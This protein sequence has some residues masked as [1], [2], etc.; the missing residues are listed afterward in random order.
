MANRHF[1]DLSPRQGPVCRCAKKLRHG[2]LPPQSRESCR[3]PS[4]ESCREKSTGRGGEVATLPPGSEVGGMA[5]GVDGQ[6]QTA[7]EAQF[8]E[9]IGEVALG[10]F[11]ADAQLVGD[12][13]VGGARDD[14][15]DDLALA[16]R[17]VPRWAL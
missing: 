7:G 12:L 13:A 5:Q 3:T 9:D 4:H 16:R 8:L 14:L 2:W 15:P 17:Q 6:F 10:G 11:L 1:F